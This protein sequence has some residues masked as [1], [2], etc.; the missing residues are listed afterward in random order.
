[1][2]HDAFLFVPGGIC[3]RLASAET[4]TI[5][6]FLLYLSLFERSRNIYTYNHIYIQSTHRIILYY[7]A[8]YHVMLCY[9][10][11]HYITL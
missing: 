10:I 2:C 9:L 7:I 8:L 4:W 11:L 5:R 1:M 6:Q 3:G